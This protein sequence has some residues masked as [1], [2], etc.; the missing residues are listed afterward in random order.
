MIGEHSLKRMF[1]REIT[2]DDVL[3]KART[4]NVIKDY[5]DDKPYPVFLMLNF[6]SKPIYEVVTKNK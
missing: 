4:R 5:L 1:E 3:S 6:I 2:P